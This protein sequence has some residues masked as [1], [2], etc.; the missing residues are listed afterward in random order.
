MSRRM[1]MG[2]L[3]QVNLPPNRDEPPA[4]GVAPGSLQ[5]GSFADLAD[6]L[7]KRECHD[8]LPDGV[9]AV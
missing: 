5:R 7:T 4:A 9:T 8:A 3:R 2:Q 1:L 6:F